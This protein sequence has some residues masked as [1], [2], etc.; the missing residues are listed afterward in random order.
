MSK[1]DDFLKKTMRTPRSGFVLLAHFG[2]WLIMG[3]WSLL[4]FF[5]TF[6]SFAMM[7]VNLYKSPEYLPLAVL[8][9]VCLFFK[10]T[11]PYL[12]AFL[13]WLIYPIGFPF[14]AERNEWIKVRWKGMLLAIA[15]P[16]IMLTCF[17][18][19]AGEDEV[20]GVPAS[21]DYHSAKD[22]YE[23]TG[24]EFPEVIPVDSS[25]Y[26]AYGVYIV[27]V[28]FVPQ[29]KPEKVFYERLDVACKQDTLHWY[30][31]SDAYFF[32]KGNGDDFFN[33][34]IPKKG[35]TISVHYGKND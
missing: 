8:P 12:L 27:T 24:V 23:A 34:Y 9:V 18:L 26:S 1:K 21:T 11:R 35:D 14:T 30:D 28:R 4:W 32:E 16:V 20:Y 5:F 2:W 22:L 3:L 19:L 7:V 25:D 13:I 31:E 29:Q 6:L 15:H 10:R 33:V 17:S